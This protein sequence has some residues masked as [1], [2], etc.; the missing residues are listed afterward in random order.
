[1]EVYK[2]SSE[3][4]HFVIK[5]FENPKFMNYLLVKR[6]VTIDLSST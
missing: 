3:I 6:H 4:V 5:S 2:M 1:M